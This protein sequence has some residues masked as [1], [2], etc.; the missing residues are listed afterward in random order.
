M[1]HDLDAHLCLLHD[2]AQPYTAEKTTKVFGEIWLGK[3]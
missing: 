2:N 1:K 3:P